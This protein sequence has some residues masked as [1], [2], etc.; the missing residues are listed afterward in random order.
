MKIVAALCWYDEEPAALERLVLSLEGIADVLVA[1]DGPFLLY[2]GQPKSSSEQADA[3]RF[4]AAR[5]GIRMEELAPRVWS[6][7]VAKRK[8]LT[9]WASTTRYVERDEE[10][11]MLVVDADEYVLRADPDELRARLAA[12]ERDVAY[13]YGEDTG[14][15]GELGRWRRLFR[16]RPELTVWNAHNEYVIVEAS[17]SVRRLH[18]DP[19]DGDLDEPEDLSDLLVLGHDAGGRPFDRQKAARRYYVLRN[20]S[21]TER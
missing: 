3:L 1:A 17:Q 21:E 18:G 2:G 5:I 9:T 10:S 4:A 7:Q 19:R 16:C 20:Q 11:W 8:L 15:R 6:T 12:T 13:V 14:R